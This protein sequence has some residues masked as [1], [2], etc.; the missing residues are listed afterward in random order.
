[1]S[2][3]TFVLRRGPGALRRSAHIAKFN[4][5]GDITGALCGRPVNMS[6]NVPWGQPRCKD[7]LRLMVKVSA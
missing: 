2:N 4:Q 3:V 6:S 5:L 7:C 1:M